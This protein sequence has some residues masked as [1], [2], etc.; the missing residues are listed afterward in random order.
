LWVGLTYYATA[1]FFLA[2]AQMHGFSK[3]ISA[4]PR[5]FKAGRDWVALAHA[6]GVAAWGRD[7]HPGVIALWR[8]SAVEYVVRDDDPPDRLAEMADQGITLVQISR[9]EPPPSAPP[10]D[11]RPL[12]VPPAVEVSP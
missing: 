8:P 11:G 10:A 1:K 3:R 7:G 12:F 4:V 9:V 6:K 2:E 5:H